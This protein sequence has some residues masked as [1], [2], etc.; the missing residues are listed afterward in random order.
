M[1][2]FFRKYNKMLLAFFM[3]LLMVVF[4]GGSALQGLLTPNVSRTVA[5]SD[6]GSIGGEHFREAEAITRILGAMGMNWT[7]PM[8]PGHT[9]LEKVDWILL[10]REVQ[11]YQTQASIPAVKA[12]FQDENLDALIDGVS[13]QLR[14]KPN[15]IYQAIAQYKSVQVAAQAVAGAAIPSAAEVRVAARDRLSKVKVRVVVLPAA[16]FAD[17]Q[18]E[19]SEE[20]LQEHWSKFSDAKPERGLNFGYY[21]E[22]A[23]SVQYIKIDLGVLA[24]QIR[25]ANH[26]K[27]AKRYFDESRE[28]DPAFRRPPEED[29]EPDEADLEGPPQSAQE[30]P[31]S[32]YLDWEEAKAAAM[33]IVRR[34]HAEEAAE[35]I[36][37]WLCH[38]DAEEWLEVQRERTGYKPAPE[39]VASLDYYDRIVGQIPPTISYPE[40]V[41][42]VKTDEFFRA[43][44]HEVEGIGFATY[45][46]GRSGARPMPFATLAFRSQPVAEQVPFESGASYTDYLSQYQT[47]PYPLTDAEGN[48]YVFRPV[49]ATPGHASES[50][51]EVRERV[52]E[53]LQ[54]LRGYELAQSW[55]QTLREYSVDGGLEEA[56]RADDELPD[57]FASPEVQGG[58]LFDSSLVSRSESD[59]VWAGSGIGQVPNDVVEKWFALEDSADQL[60]IYELPDRAT[61]LVAEWAE[62]EPATLEEFEEMGEQ[63]A[64]QIR[65][66]RAREVI[67]DWLNPEHIRARNGLKVVD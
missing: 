48:R 50:V 28:S 64:L 34:Q 2:K 22:P 59:R 52:V 60:D 44:V 6:L 10:T 33:D 29:A 14:V 62:S 66:R 1:L 47:C 51:D 7:Q 55:A 40:A 9:P 46:S 67:A 15:H 23:L 21:V 31:K 65:S 27:R 57:L 45:G 24:E 5:E 26:E 32:P 11:K 39:K 36:A 49:S 8:G 17:E 63:L 25:I 53:D 16:A 38:Y 41:T 3:V 12:G 61:V 56:Y 58:G 18:R 37:I 42:V 13:R 35:R 20:E 43:D 19:F 54:L 30:E 4:V